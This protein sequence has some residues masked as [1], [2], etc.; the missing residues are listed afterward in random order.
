MLCVC[1]CVHAP[2]FV[3]VSVHL[4]CICVCT[5]MRVCV[6]VCACVVLCC[7]CLCVSMRVCACVVLC[8]VCV[9]AVCV[10]GCTGVLP[11]VIG[12]PLYWHRSPHLASRTVV[13]LV[14][15]LA[16]TAFH[17]HTNQLTPTHLVLRQ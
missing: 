8:C 3:C 1:V 15:V 17:S 16:V 11:A 5:C 4:C 6:C 9:C 13:T 10:G 2:V 7:V 12:L 14:T